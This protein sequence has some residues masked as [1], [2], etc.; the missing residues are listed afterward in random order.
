[1]SLKATVNLII[2]THCNN[3]V[4]KTVRTAAAAAAAATATT[5]LIELSDNKHCSQIHKC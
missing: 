2:Q 4:S 3:S 1:M 5:T